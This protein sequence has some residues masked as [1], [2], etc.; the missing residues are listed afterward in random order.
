MNNKSNKNKKLNDERRMFVGGLFPETSSRMVKKYF[1]RF[2]RVLDVKIIGEKQKRSRGFGFVLFESKEVYD[3]VMTQKH[4]IEGRQVDCNT[5][6]HTKKNQKSGEDESYK[7]KVFVRDLPLN[8]SKDDL[9]Q[10]FKFYGKVMQVLLVKRKNKAFTFSFVEF[11][12][13]EARN[14]V[15]EN[16][17]ET[18]LGVECKVEP[19]QPKNVNKEANGKEEPQEIVI[20]K[21]RNGHDIENFGYEKRKLN[22]TNKRRIHPPQNQ[23]KIRHASFPV[24]F[25]QINESDEDNFDDFYVKKSKSREIPSVSQNRNAPI[26]Q[27]QV[28]PPQN[29]PN[30]QNQQQNDAREDNRQHLRNNRNPGDLRQSSQDSYCSKIRL[31]AKEARNRSF[32]T[33]REEEEANIR[34]NKSKNSPDSQPDSSNLSPPAG[35][36]NNSQH[37]SYSNN[38][39]SVRMY[40]TK[41]SENHPQDNIDFYSVRSQNNFRQFDN[42]GILRSSMEG[43]GPQSQSKNNEGNQNECRSSIASGFNDESPEMINFFEKELGNIPPSSSNGRPLIRPR[44]QSHNNHLIRAY[45]IPEED[46][47]R[48]RQRSFVKLKAKAQS[49]SN[50]LEGE[51]IDTSLDNNQILEADYQKNRQIGTESDE[52]LFEDYGR[53]HFKLE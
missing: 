11:E 19:A 30:N 16:P 35:F 38:N 31:I 24:Y 37:H 1:E 15:L 48:S 36:Q 3:F 34:L 22:D 6:I 7:K 44:H 42:K 50:V 39:N 46:S 13:E 41:Y 29:I 32:N 33:S 20:S 47:M 14:Q 25:D 21:K 28:N 45:E 8:V 53:E 23:R 5:A 26:H 12:T 51:E 18:I 27:I 4:T 40:S 17:V 2:G 49:S 43:T 10:H 52:Q 9:I